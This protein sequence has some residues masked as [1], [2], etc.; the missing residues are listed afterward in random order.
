M[1]QRRSF[2]ILLF[3]SVSVLFEKY[4]FSSYLQSLRRMVSFLKR[5]SVPE[6][7]KPSPKLGR[8]VK[9][10]ILLHLVQTGWLRQGFARLGTGHC[11][12]NRAKVINISEAY[13]VTAYLN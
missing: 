7:P 11:F 4:N 2:Q 1:G 13:I 12:K 3:F 8:F 10:M 9:E 5:N 6:L